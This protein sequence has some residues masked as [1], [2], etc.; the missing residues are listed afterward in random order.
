MGQIPRERL[1]A[2]RNPRRMRILDRAIPRQVMG[3]GEAPKPGATIERLTHQALHGDLYGVSRESLAQCRVNCG[4]RG[5]NATDAAHHSVAPD[6]GRAA[7][8]S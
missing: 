6:K 4:K 8:N 2:Q 7:E 5:P 3:R 1:G